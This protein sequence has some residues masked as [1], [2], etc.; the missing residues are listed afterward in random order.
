MTFTHKHPD[1]IG[2]PERQW[3]RIS[4][5]VFQKCLLCGAV[6]YERPEDAERLDQEP[7]DAVPVFTPAEANE[8]YARL[9]AW[10]LGIPEDAEIPPFGDLLQQ[11]R[12]VQRMR[13]DAVTPPSFQLVSNAIYAMVTNWD[14]LTPVQQHTCREDLRT[15]SKSLPKIDPKTL[16]S[17]G[18][19]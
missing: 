15:F 9:L 6:G 19:W 11:V 5:A 2:R 1:C 7:E 4:G 18:E 12:G 14:K 10:A 8:K 3:S 13:V 17:S 16:P